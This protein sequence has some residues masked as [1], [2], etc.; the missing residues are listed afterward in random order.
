MKNKRQQNQII[1]GLNMCVDCG[2]VRR[3]IERKFAWIKLR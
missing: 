1:I 3:F 2:D